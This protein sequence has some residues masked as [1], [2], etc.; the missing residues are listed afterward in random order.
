MATGLAGAR[1][2]ESN[3]GFAMYAPA[4]IPMAPRKSLREQLIFMVR[5]TSQ[6]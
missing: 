5:P 1:S 3:D 2:A 4:A 6:V